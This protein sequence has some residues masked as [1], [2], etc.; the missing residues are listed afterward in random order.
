MAAAATIIWR[1]TPSEHVRAV[2][3]LQAYH[4]RQERRLTRELRVLFLALLGL[5]GIA[6][7]AWRWWTTRQPPLELLI[8]IGIPAVLLAS[9]LRWRRG[10]VARAARRQLETNPLTLQE[11]R[12]TFDGRGMSVAGETFEDKF[13]WREV[14]HIAETPEFF[15]IFAARSAYYLPKRAV[16]W[17]ETIENLREVLGEY[18]GERARVR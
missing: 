7:I 2:G 8:G 16:T 15:L 18:L 4:A 14:K 1:V 13:G 3:A 6:V 17:P 5:A 10:S 9:F 12:Y 11:R